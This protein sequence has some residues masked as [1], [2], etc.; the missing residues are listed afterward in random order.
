MRKEL[1]AIYDKAA[2][3]FTDPAPFINEALA[4]RAFAD[5]VSGDGV[6]HSHPDDFDFYLVGYY[7]SSN[8]CMLSFDDVIVPKLICRGTD[9]VDI[10]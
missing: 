1:Y 3:F 5:L 6:H 8:G 2:Q 10:R 4:K 7:D 9:Y